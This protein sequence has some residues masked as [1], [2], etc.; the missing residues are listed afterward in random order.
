MSSQ[1]RSARPAQRAAATLLLSLMAAGLAACDS[2]RVADSMHPMLT[3]HTKRHPIGI[4]DDSV[5][6]DLP[7]VSGVA[8]DRSRDTIAAMRF[9]RKYKQEGRG[10]LVVAVA[11]AGRRQWGVERRLD[12]IRRIARAAGVG[13]DRMRFTERAHPESI[14]AAVTLSYERLAVVAPVCGDWSENVARNPDNLPYPN[15][16][17]ASQRNLAAMIANPT[18]VVFPAEET[19]RLSDNRAPAYAAYKG[20]AGASTSTPPSGTSATQ[21]S[22]STAAPKL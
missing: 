14:G 22:P 15:Y 7:P 9:V 4:A 11:A 12:Q 2:S 13:P 6:L 5:L 1:T 21:A 19:P 8:A 20:N 17:C 3:D 16:G 18:D 10:P